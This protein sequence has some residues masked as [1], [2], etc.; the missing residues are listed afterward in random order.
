MNIIEKDFEYIVP[1]FLDVK[2]T[3]KF[4]TAK[5]KYKGPDKFYVL[6]DE[7]NRY[8]FSNLPYDEED[9]N[10]ENVLANWSDGNNYVFVDAH[11]HLLF[12]YLVFTESFYTEEESQAAEKEMLTGPQFEHYA[13]GD[14]DPFYFY[15]KNL[16]PETT[17]SIET[18]T[19]NAEKDQWQIDFDYIED[20]SVE[21]FEEELEDNIR[22]VNKLIESSEENNL[23]TDDIHLLKE[24]LKE[25][26]SI[27]VRYA[28][29]PV[30]IWPRPDDPLDKGDEEGPAEEQDE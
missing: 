25:F 24:Y 26:E 18:A 19:Y 28:D 30:S 2:N 1:D 9:E 20:M 13:K 7:N 15:P 11:K 6:I 10:F 12:A 17:Y 22:R 16:Q 3:A 14:T 5:R 8:L 27:P 4:Y 21:D 23:S 29:Y